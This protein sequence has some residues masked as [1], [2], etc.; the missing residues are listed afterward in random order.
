MDITHGGIGSTTSV[1]HEEPTSGAPCSEMAM[2]SSKGKHHKI[3]LVARSAL[4]CLEA[5]SFE[6]SRLSR[7]IWRAQA[8]VGQVHHIAKT[9]AIPTAC[10]IRNPP[11][12]F[13]Y[14]T[15]PFPGSP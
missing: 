11:Q 3:I 8:I 13:C 14:R 1:E 2:F 10:G 7:E 6:I 9:S 5:S 15:L 12:L 4:A